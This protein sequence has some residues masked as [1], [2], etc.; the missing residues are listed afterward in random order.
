MQMENEADENDA[1]GMKIR[2]SRYH[3]IFQRAFPLLTS[4]I[5]TFSHF[6]SQ[7]FSKEII[8]S[9]LH[10]TSRRKCKKHEILEFC[11]LS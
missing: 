9:L 6:R 8:E 3:E 11:F 4:I 10:E 7:S 2:I 5:C 1:T